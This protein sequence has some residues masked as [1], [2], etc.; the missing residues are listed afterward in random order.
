MPVPRLYVDH[1]LQHGTLIS[2]GKPQAHYLATVLRLKSGDAV[3]LFNGRDGEWHGALATLD[4]KGAAVRLQTQFRPQS[5]EPDVWLLFAPIKLGRID[6]LVEKATEL[7]AARLCPV[8]TRRTVVTRVNEARLRAHIVEAAEQSERLTL[9]Q[10]APYASL[11]KT[12]AEWPA[13]RLL[14]YADE[15]GGGLP[16]LELLPA[17]STG[18]LAVLIGPEGGF[19]PEELE[20]LRRLPFASPMSLGPRVLRADTAALAAL[21][22]VMATHGDWRDGRPA[23]K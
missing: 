4:R 3:A 10:L 6:F 8:Q 2:L 12:L 16:P 18:K 1:P 15:T 17:L 13:D 23:F 21:T 7:G 14:L 20:I 22:C 11:E 9:P 19:A 5:A